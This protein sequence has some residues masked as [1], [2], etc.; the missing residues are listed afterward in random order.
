MGYSSESR[1]GA[2]FYVASVTVVVESKSEFGISVKRQ[3]E[4]LFSGKNWGI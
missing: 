4:I 2:Q 1:A 3:K